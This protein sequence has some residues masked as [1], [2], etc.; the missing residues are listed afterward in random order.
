[1]FD[2]LCICEVGE[3][4][5]CEDCFIFFGGVGDEDCF[6]VLCDLLIDECGIFVGFVVLEDEFVE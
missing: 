3:C 2:V 5:G 6:D 4:V 1:M